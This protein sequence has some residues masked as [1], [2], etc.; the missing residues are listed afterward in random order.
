MEEARIFAEK[1]ISSWNTHNLD[2]ILSHYAEDIE[3]TTPMIRIATGG[4]QSTLTGKQA[5]ANY[6]A[7]ALKKLPDLKF[8]LVEVTTGVHSV[9]LYYKSV[10]GKMAIEVMFF[11]QEGKVNKMMAHY[12]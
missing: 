12:T 8:E 2:D 3:V 9:A 6:W 4:E 5:V 10:M 1:W 7:T 11:N